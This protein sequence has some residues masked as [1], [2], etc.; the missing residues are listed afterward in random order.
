MTENEENEDVR[1]AVKEALQEGRKE[2]APNGVKGWV[3]IL[4]PT[5]VVGIVMG[6]ITFGTL[7]SDLGHVQARA[8][9]TRE[10][11]ANL[12]GRVNEISNRLSAVEGKAESVRRSTVKIQERVDEIAK[13]ERE[14][15]RELVMQLRGDDAAGH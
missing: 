1:K 5:I 7:Q 11:I 10:E 14:R 12:R 4:L 15:Y 9:E 8:S 13:R 3:R 2:F 6:F